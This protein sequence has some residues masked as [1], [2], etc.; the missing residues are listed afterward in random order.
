MRTEAQTSIHLFMAGVVSTFSVMLTLITLAMLW[1]PWTVVLT[2]VG[3]FVVWWLHIGRIGSDLLYE[4]ICAGLLMMEFF[5]FGVHSTSL[6]DIP[7]V[8][9]V[10]LVSLSLLSRKLLLY[11]IGALYVVML[12]YHFLLLQTISAHMGLEGALRMVLGAASV[13]GVVAVGRYRINRRHREQRKYSSMQ[14]QLQTAVRQNA[15]FLSNVDRK[16]VV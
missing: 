2:V 13:A 15:D 14:E 9:C 4:N 5:F 12:L 6:Y 11:L 8:A 10:L 1:E 16:S 3:C 7:L